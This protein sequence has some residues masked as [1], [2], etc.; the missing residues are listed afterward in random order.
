VT[1]AK[2]CT[3]C[4]RP[5]PLD[6]VKNGKCPD[7][8]RAYERQKTRRA[9]DERQGGY[10]RVTTGSRWKKARA[11]ALARAGNACELRNGHCRG[12][13]EVHHKR[14]VREGGAPYDAA[15]LIVVCRHHHETLEHRTPMSRSERGTLVRSG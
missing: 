4:Q 1:S 15:N 14:K 6:Q 11:Q 7:C 8:L 10:R 12:R 3:A 5:F 9:Q 13:L 2:L